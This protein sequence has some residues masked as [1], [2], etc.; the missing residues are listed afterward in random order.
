MRKCFTLIYF[1]FNDSFPY[2]IIWKMAHIFRNEIIFLIWTWKITRHQSFI[3]NVVFNEKLQYEKFFRSK[4]VDLNETSIGSF[5]RI[6]L[7][8][9]DING[10]E[11]RNFDR[12]FRDFSRFPYYFYINNALAWRFPLLVLF[13]LIELEN[14]SGKKQLVRFSNDS[15]L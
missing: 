2:W 11:T 6:F 4:K 7:F 14:I 15:P 10:F 1:H 5:Q 13:L 12:I 9:F 3:E 8:P